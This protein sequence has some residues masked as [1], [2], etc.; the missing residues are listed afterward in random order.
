MPLFGSRGK[1][2]RGK[3]PAAPGGGLT[4]HPWQVAPTPTRTVLSA[5]AAYPGRT[6]FQMGSQSLTYRATLDLIGRMQG[7]MARFG[8]RPGDVVAG[9]SSNR[10]EAWCAGVAA[11]GLGAIITPLHP[12]GSLHDHVAQ[13][14]DTEA[15]FLVVDVDRYR[16]RAGQLAEAV[17]LKKI[18]TLG[19]ARLGSDLLEAASASA[20]SAIDLSQIGDVAALNYTGGTSGRAKGVVRT[21]RELSA[22]TAC[23]LANFPLPR[24][25]RFLAVAP[26]THM[27]G[28]FVAPVLARGGT[29]DLMA[30]FSPD[31]VVKRI[32][33]NSVNFTILVPSMIYAM[34]DDPSWSRE[35]VRS[36]DLLVYGASPMS[37]TRLSEGLERFG[38]VFFQLYGQTECFV[39]SALGFDDHD[40]N[41][42]HL[43]A[44]AGRPM[45][46]CDVKIRSD[47][48]QDVA[49]G[50][51]GEICVRSPYA[52]Q[53][54]WKQRNCSE[55][56]LRDG[57]I[58]TGDVAWRDEEGRIYIVDRKKDLIVSGGFNIYPRDVED[59]LRA[60]PGVI[61]AAVVGVPDPKWG[62]AVKAFVV[63]RSNDGPSADI[64]SAWVKERKGTTHAPKSFDFVAELPLTAL[65]KVDKARLR[66]PFWSGLDRAVN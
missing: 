6:A 28:L 24:T 5:L 44:S 18:L 20:Y 52:M 47:E 59:A 64:L 63:R 41:R 60:H 2:R 26:I 49:P 50:Q 58:H 38:P 21:H 35:N 17:S 42:P 27:A 48:A 13:I 55:E 10:V 19:K 11:Q 14:E 32:Q 56:V 7:A 66:A 4:E 8:V 23:I 62:E 22:G 30:S 45:I 39:I 15:S 16:E 33:D 43:L 51:R 65:G 54:Y 61:D 57:W 25:P 40:L 1:G 31:G 37:P 53:G 36:L 34:L 46:E 29:V 12:L 9:L 3:G